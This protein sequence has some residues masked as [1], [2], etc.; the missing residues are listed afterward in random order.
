MTYTNDDSTYFCQELVYRKSKLYVIEYMAE[1]DFYINVQ[2]KILLFQNKKDIK[3][4][5]EKA[6][7]SIKEE[8]ILEERINLDKL[9]NW[10]KEENSVVNNS[11]FLT[12]W[13]FFDDVSISIGKTFI[14]NNNDYD[15]VYTKLF[16]GN[17]LLAINTSGKE[18]NPEWNESEVIQFNRVME[19][20]L[21]LFQENIEIYGFLNR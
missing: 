4:Y 9:V 19:N 5:T 18:Y 12:L 14:G 11:E 3:K 7:I 20:G 10:L 8:D 15:R 6:K 13:N 17:N 2:N 21:K 16:Y 1:K